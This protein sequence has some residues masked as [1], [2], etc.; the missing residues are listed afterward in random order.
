MPRS[1]RIG[2][3]GLRRRSLAPCPKVGSGP[4][5]AALGEFEALRD[6]PYAAVAA[7]VLARFAG[8]IPRGEIAAMTARAYGAD[9]FDVP[10]IVSLQRL[11]PGVHL[12][13]LSHGPTLAFKDMALQPFG[14]VLSALAQQRRDPLQQL[15]RVPRAAVGVE[16]LGHDPQGVGGGEAA[17]LRPGPAISVGSVEPR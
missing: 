14:V 5:P 6:A 13:G 16:R 17:A 8:D 1:I 3:F 9:V 7:D 4:R 2:S 15:R 11:E 10:E 12:A